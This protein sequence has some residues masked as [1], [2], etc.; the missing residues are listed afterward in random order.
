MLCEL[1][2]N[3]YIF[4]RS[5]GFTTSFPSI[6]TIGLEPCVYRPESKSIGLNGEPIEH[7]ASILPL[8]EAKLAEQNG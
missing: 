2:I 7:S 4:Q 1:A 8:Q 3:I 6:D 5:V